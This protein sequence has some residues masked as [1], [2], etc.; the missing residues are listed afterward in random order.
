MLGMIESVRIPRLYA[1]RFEVEDLARQSRALSWLISIL[2]REI[3]RRDP[4]L[5]KLPTVTQNSLQSTT[6]TYEY[7]RTDPNSI[8]FVPE[9]PFNVV[10]IDGSLYVS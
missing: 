2:A 5:A 8:T 6:S 1:R 3:D 9:V 7:D 4:S 10:N